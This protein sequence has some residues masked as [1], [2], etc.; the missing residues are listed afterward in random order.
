MRRIEILNA[1][2]KTSAQYSIQFLKNKNGKLPFGVIGDTPP[3]NPISPNICV[4]VLG[5]EGDGGFEAG[6]KI[7]GHLTQVV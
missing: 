6:A 5:G 3:Y 7:C 1:T 4:S 2:Q